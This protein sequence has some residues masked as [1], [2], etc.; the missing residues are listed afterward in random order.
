VRCHH[1]QNPL[2]ALHTV[3]DF[4]ISGNYQSVTGVHSLAVDLDASNM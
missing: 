1:H 4:I 3:I 2:A